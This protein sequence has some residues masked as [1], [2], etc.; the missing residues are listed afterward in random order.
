MIQKRISSLNL[1]V[2][3]YFYDIVKFRLIL[4]NVN[5]FTIYEFLLYKLTKILPTIYKNKAKV[6]VEVPTSVF[7]YEES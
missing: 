2:N 7:N 4:N 1:K 6:A 5:I 3:C